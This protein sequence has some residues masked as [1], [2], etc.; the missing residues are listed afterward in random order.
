M[1]RQRVA[2][3]IDAMT[4]LICGSGLQSVPLASQRPGN[5]ACSM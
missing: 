4:G 5:G 2:V 3:A 1:S